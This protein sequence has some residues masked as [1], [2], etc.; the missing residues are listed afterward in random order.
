MMSYTLAFAFWTILALS[1]CRTP[2]G[3]GS[4]LGEAAARGDVDRLQALLQTGSSPNE[5]DRDGFSALMTAARCGQ[6]SAIRV[7]I[8]SGADPD[9]CSGRNG[10]TPLLHAIHKGQADA[11][12]ELL[13]QGAEVN[14]ATASGLTPL[15]MASGYGLTDIVRILLSHG[16]D[17]WKSN[18]QGETAVT[19]AALGVMDIDAF[20]FGSCQ[21]ETVQALL[22]HEPGLS[23]NVKLGGLDLLILRM[24][25]RDVLALLE[26]PAR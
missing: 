18:R 8:G 14:A 22:D 4:P 20:T 23:R 2:P 6:L 24:R 7:L 19:L 16:A 12:V 26:H 1:A 3:H 10:W 17:V 5:L 21:L 25:C 11:V 15:M 13:R 9:L